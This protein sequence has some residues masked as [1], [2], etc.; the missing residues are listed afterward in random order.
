MATVRPSTL[1][2]LNTVLFGRCPRCSLAPKLSRDP[3]TPLP[4]D[5]TVA[6]EEA[7]AV[8][9]PVEIALVLAVVPVVMASGFKSDC[10]LSTPL[11][12]SLLIGDSIITAVTVPLGRGGGGAVALPVALCL[13]RGDSTTTT[14]F[15]RSCCN[16]KIV[17][18]NLNFKVIFSPLSE[19]E[20]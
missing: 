1:A 11:I 3:A 14:V 17:Q 20:P 5:V 18:P 9:S 10:M 16:V 7:A 2:A 15:S 4:P 8:S 12:D 19:V 13:L 6:A